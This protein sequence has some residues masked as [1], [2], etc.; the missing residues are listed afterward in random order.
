MCSAS[1]YLHIPFCVSKC[2]YCDFY[3]VPCRRRDDP[4]LDALVERLLD[5]ARR[6]VHDLGVKHIPTLYIGGGTPS[7]L[8]A[9]R[10]AWLLTGLE[11]LWQKA[12]DELTVEVN[13]ESL[14]HA[15]LIACRNN[16]VTRISVGVQ[17][18]HEPSR[19]AI[20]RAGSAARALE[21][22]DMVRRVFGTAFS[23]DL[24]TGLP[25]QDN[26][27]L[28][29]DIKTLLAYQPAHV[30]LY[31][32]TLEPDTPMARMARQDKR[33]LPA[34]ERA[35]ALYIAARDALEQASYSQY[36][37]SNFALN[38][39]RGAHNLR[40]WRMENW[41][42]LGPAA[43]STIIDDNSGTGIRYTWE[44]D[45]DA[46]LT[47][48]APLVERLDQLT[49]MKETLLMGFRYIDGPDLA[50][51]QKRFG[52]PLEASIPRSLAA[53]Q[54]LLVSSPSGYALSKDGLLLLNRF[55]LDIFTE[56]DTNTLDTIR[57]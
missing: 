50:L 15:F 24:I 13:P 45:V 39:K 5:D 47:G 22:L 49:L 48:S 41:L 44:R 16:G 26:A 28:L 52:Q 32:L 4:R 8:G 9:A 20:R 40:Y 30:S 19:A 2:A 56:L 46:Y 1:L 33:L 34:P 27:V 55:L 51:F 14:D 6:W 25:F 36:E 43:S 53:W 17:S 29:K 3:S 42:G 31:A 23:A 11:R 57:A 35:D 10:I 18:F 37:V 21:C 38:N 54:S 12:P 7:L